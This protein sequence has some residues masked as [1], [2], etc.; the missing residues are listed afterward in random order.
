M[1][2]RKELKIVKEL[3]EINNDRRIVLNDT[4]LTSRVYIIDYGEYVFKFLKNKKYQEELEHEANI[5]KLIKNYD[6]NV[7]IPLIKWVGEGKEYIGFK[8]MTGRSMT[9]DIINE[10]SEN[11]RKEVGKQIGVFLKTLHAI[12]YKG[13][14]P[15]NE[16]SVIKWLLSSFCK[17]RRTLKKYF[18]ENELSFIEKLVTSLPEKS[19]KHGIE[20]V[21]CHGDLGYNNIIISDQLQVGIIDF[22]DAGNLD[23]SY[24]FIGLEDDIMLDAAMQAYGGDGNLKEKVAIRRQ[25]LPLMEMLFF[26]DRKDNVEIEKS[27][28]KM[29]N[30][31][32]N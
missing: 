2:K 16:S 29:R 26:I 19:S 17:R 1:E 20:E 9:S 13:E 24:D 21:F 25:L 7:N 11:Q 23:K 14:N 28:G 8:G 22:G 30:N 4:G 6:F 12:E 10:L 27:A 31:L 18:N 5:L 3:T 32:K 15:N